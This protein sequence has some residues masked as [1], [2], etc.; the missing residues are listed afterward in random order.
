[1]ID[2]QHLD[3]SLLRFQLQPKLVFQCLEEGAAG[4]RG[5][6][7]RWCL[8]ASTR[9][10]S[11]IRPQARSYRSPGRGSVASPVC[12]GIDSASI[13]SVTLRP[14]KR[15][16]SGALAGKCA[17]MPHGIGRAA[18][19]TAARTATTCSP[20]PSGNSVVA[21]SSLAGCGL[22]CGPSFPGF[23]SASAN[24]GASRVSQCTASL[25]R[26]ASRLCI[27]SRI[28]SL[29]ARR[30]R[31]RLNVV[32]VLL[33]PSGHVQPKPGVVVEPQR[34]LLRSTQLV[35]KDDVAHQR[36]VVRRK[37]GACGSQRIILADREVR[38]P[39]V[40]REIAIWPPIGIFLPH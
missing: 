9:S 19:D 16:A 32:A 25:N 7:L 27:I 29:V 14:P 40:Q 6:P 2:H 30:R 11:R 13:A 23:S 33:H 34:Q 21:Q 8:P 1:M 10:R 22:S 3:R 36:L 20:G 12:A 4:S 5:Y 39:I 28:W 37:Q 18:S 31:A 17:I 35:C 15:R 38:V 24:T 26:S